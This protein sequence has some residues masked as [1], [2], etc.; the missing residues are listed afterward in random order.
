MLLPGSALEGGQ[1]VLGGH[2][3][4]G[5]E[6]LERCGLVDPWENHDPVIHPM[7]QLAVRKVL[8]RTTDERSQI[9]QD[10]RTIGRGLAAIISPR[11]GVPLR[12]I[13][14]DADEEPSTFPHLLS[15][16]WTL[17]EPEWRDASHLDELRLVVHVVNRLRARGLLTASVMLTDALFEDQTV[18]R[19]SWSVEET[20]ELAEIYAQ[21]GVAFYHGGRGARPSSAHTWFARA[22]TLEET[23][24]ARERDPMWSRRVLGLQ[25]W[26]AVSQHLESKNAA[27]ALQLV[28]ELEALLPEY[29]RPETPAR[30]LAFALARLAFAYDE[31]ASHERNAERRD[32]LV[33]KARSLIT[34]ADGLLVQ[35]VAGDPIEHANLCQRRAV[36]GLH[37]AYL[38]GQDGGAFER[39]G[40]DI[41]AVVQS[42]RE[43]KLQMHVA[44]ARVLRSQAHVYA[45][46]D[47]LNA[48]VDAAT[49]SVYIERQGGNVGPG[50]AEANAVLG[51]M[52]L[53]R[54]LASAE[55]AAR[56]A[57]LDVA[58]QH[59]GEAL[60]SATAMMPRTW[61]LKETIEFDLCLLSQARPRSR[62]G[63][64][65]LKSA[66]AQ[67]ETRLGSYSV[68]LYERRKLLNL[69]SR[70][71]P[72]VDRP[73]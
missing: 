30:D 29:E 1:R 37:V 26:R 44:F 16:A 57:D 33:E 73:S 23:V 15:M 48:A 10:F 9:A 47:Q 41:A 27:R 3:E 58:E 20:V 11:G 71:T 6:G 14:P 4:T 25:Y 24:P 55:G 21:A 19:H 7:I 42:Y 39:L 22:L 72:P 2:L 46:C 68:D 50:L 17:S 65:A 66:L 8:S 28:H 40:A 54:F 12:S 49:E 63:A 31:A 52:S 18:D 38:T 36:V 56:R 62:P 70:G 53:W 45:A 35:V 59:L 67:L 43:T 60:V 32:S 64:P 51:Q 61:Q 34:R 69:L 13:V 5:L